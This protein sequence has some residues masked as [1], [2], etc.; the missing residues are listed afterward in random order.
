MAKNAL[1]V[2]VRF[3]SLSLFSETGLTTSQSDSEL[4]LDSVSESDSTF[5]ALFF[6]TLVVLA[7]ILKYD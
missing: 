7:Y 6:A 4:E 1:Y 3:F 5:T 2:S